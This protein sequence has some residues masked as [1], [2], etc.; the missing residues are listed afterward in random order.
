ME[1]GVSILWNPLCGMSSCF[2]YIPILLA[3]PM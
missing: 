2:Q 1:I 3:T